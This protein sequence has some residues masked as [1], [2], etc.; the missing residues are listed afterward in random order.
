LAQ[1]PK[2]G[3]EALNLSEIAAVPV[4]QVFG[5]MFIRDETSGNFTIVAAVWYW[6]WRCQSPVP[7]SRWGG[8]GTVQPVACPASC[9]VRENQVFIFVC[10]DVRQPRQQH[11]GRV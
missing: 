6:I 7:L 10:G 9:R 1:T 11:D 5:L 4:M 3:R 8:F 2:R